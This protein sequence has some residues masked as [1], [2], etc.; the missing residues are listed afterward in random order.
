LNIHAINYVSGVLQMAEQVED[1]KADK[2]RSS[3]SRDPIVSVAKRNKDLEKRTQQVLSSFVL[4]TFAL[5]VSVVGNIYQ[6]S[7]KVEHVY[8]V[9]NID[10]TGLTKIQ[11]IDQPISS[12]GA[13]T[14]LVV[15]AISDLNALDFANYKRQLS[16]A[17]P[18][19][20]NKGWGRYTEEFVSSGTQDVIEKRQLV[21]SGAV[22]KPPVITAEG[23][24][25]AG[26]PYYWDVE[27][28]YLVRYQGAGYDQQQTS[29]AV[30]KVI[31]VP[32]SERP[33]GIAIAS[34]SGRAG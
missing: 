24:L 25:Y 26:G 11:P 13:V 12:K 30:V 19:F 7:R 10:G 2:K 16:S 15:D 27:V 5:L 32:V 6:G 20:T 31:R 21:M 29:I 14:Q 22:T 3:I 33:K 8:F 4:I 17:S 23:Q 1:K 9:Q 28:P 18:Y 34:F